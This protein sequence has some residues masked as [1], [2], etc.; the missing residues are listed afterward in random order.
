MGNPKPTL[1]GKITPWKEKGTVE[2]T[3]EKGGP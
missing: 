2:K 3:R 1:K